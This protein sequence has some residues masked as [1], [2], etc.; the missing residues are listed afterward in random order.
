MDVLNVNGLSS[1]PWNVSVGGTDFYYSDYASGAPSAATLWNQTND[2]SNGSLKAPIPE[3]PWDNAL[4]FDVL[5]DPLAGG[6]GGGG[7]SNCSQETV[8]RGRPSEL[9]CGVSQAVV[10]ERSGGPD[11]QARDLP[12][13]SSFASNGANLSATPICAEPGDYAW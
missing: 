7:V 6:A 9:H 13:V 1:T 4:G 8:P 2:S 5:F 12:D 11:D 10:A 3:Q